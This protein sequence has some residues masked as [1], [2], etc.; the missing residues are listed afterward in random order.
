VNAK[1]SR[2]WHA[3]EVRAEPPASQRAMMS[4]I[5]VREKLEAAHDRL[6]AT[7]E[8][9]EARALDG[10]LERGETPNRRSLARLRTDG[11]ALEEEIKDLQAALRGAEKY[12]DQARQRAAKSAR[13]DAA[14]KVLESSQEMFEAAQ[15]FSECATALVVRGR[16][17]LDLVDQAHRAGFGASKALV[18]ANLRRSLSGALHA[19]DM[20]LGDLQPPSS[21]IELGTLLASYAQR[22][23]DEAQRVLDEGEEAA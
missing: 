21:R 9:R 19:L 7:N 12:L 2:L 23:A 5:E 1:D 8:E 17:Y 20:H 13:R 3:T 14:Q 18:A 10:M 11:A 15:L 4:V 22:V 6:Q 16:R